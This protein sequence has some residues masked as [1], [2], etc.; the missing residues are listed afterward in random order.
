MKTESPRLTIRGKSRRIINVFITGGDFSK[1]RETFLVL[2]GE[3]GEKEWWGLWECW[4]L[5]F[6]VTGALRKVT[7][8]GIRYRKWQWLG[9]PGS[10]ALL[11]VIFFFST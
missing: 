8:E 3:G 2:H 6:K 5:T 10:G 1:R 11:L 4:I 9:C 7:E